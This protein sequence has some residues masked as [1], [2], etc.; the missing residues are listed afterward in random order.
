MRIY[1]YALHS[2]DSSVLLLSSVCKGLS[3]NPTQ[4]WYFCPT[5]HLSQWGPITVHYTVLILL[6]SVCE[7]LSLSPLHST[8]SSVLLLSSVCKG[9]SVCPTKYWFFCPTYILSL[10]GPITEPYT[11][12]I[13]LFYFYP[14]SVRA[15]HWPLQSTDT[16]VLLLSSV[17]KGLS[18]SPTKYWFFCPTSVLSQWGPI[19]EHYTVLIF[20]SSVCE[21]LSL[22]PL[23]STDSSVLL[24]SSVCEG[25]S[26]S[27]T[28]YWFSCPTSVLSPWGPITVHYTV[29]RT[30][31]EI[32]LARNPGLGTHLTTDHSPLLENL[33]SII[34]NSCAQAWT[35]QSCPRPTK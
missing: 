23:H 34:Y 16:S 7:G 24:L 15:Y 20:L 30:T 12:L 26:L 11:V 35:V 32:K 3:L 19:T 31:G 14:Q 17:C 9:L 18:V 6:S 10:W 8:D 22:S 25:L 28:K 13:L 1:H 2:T 33:A 21:G 5:S 29:L 4:Y 27:T